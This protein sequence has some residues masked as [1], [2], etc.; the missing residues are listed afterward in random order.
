M[1]IA[2]STM[3]ASG[4]ETYPINLAKTIDG[5]HTK[6]CRYLINQCVLTKTGQIYKAKNFGVGRNFGV[7]VQPR[8]IIRPSS[9]NTPVS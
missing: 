4:P 1:V 7:G 8:Y 5:E 9:W 2:S 6:S 3:V